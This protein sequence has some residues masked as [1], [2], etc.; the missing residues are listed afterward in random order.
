MFQKDMFIA[1]VGEASGTTYAAGVDNI[2]KLYKVDVDSEYDKDKCKGLDVMLTKMLNE[3]QDS[4]E[5]HK[6]S[7]R[8]TNL[9]R[10]VEC[11]NNNGIPPAKACQVA[12]EKVLAGYKANFDEIWKNERYKW[13]NAKHY[14]T[15]W[16]IDAENF[17]EMLAES[18]QPAATGEG[19]LLSG[20]MY[21]PYRMICAFAQE[22]PDT[23]REM[24]RML[25]DESQPLASRYSKFR[26]SSETCLK[27]Y[28]ASSAEHAKAQNHYQDLRAIM[29]YLSF[30]YPNT[31]FPFKYKMYT[32]FRDLVGF[33]EHKGKSEIW[34][35][36]CYN[37]LCEEVLTRIL[38]DSELLAM[39]KKA[40]EGDDECAPDEKYHL[41]TQTVIYVPTYMDLGLDKS[42]VPETM[43]GEPDDAAM[44][45][46]VKTDI[47]KNTILYGPPGTGKTY[48]TVLY[49]VAIIENKPLKVIQQERYEDVFLRYSDYREMGL[50]EFTTFH[51]SYGYEEF[52]EGIKP[53]MET[54]GDDSKEIEYELSSGLFKSFCEKARQPV[55]AQEQ[56]YGLNANPTVW[57]VSLAG[58]GDNGVRSDCLSKGHIRI[59]WDGYGPDITSE[60]EFTDGG[61]AILNAFMNK[62]RVG[63]IVLSCYSATTVDAIGVVT[64]EYEW[65][66]EYEDYK[67]ARNVSWIVKNIREDI[68][69]L[70]GATMTLSTVYK[71]NLGVADVMG[72][73]AKNLPSAVLPMSRVKNHVFIIDEINRGNISKIFGELITLIEPAKRLGAA[74]ETLAKLPYS[75]KMFGVPDNVYLLGTMNTADRS[76]ATI[77]TALRRRFQFREMQPDPSVLTGVMVEDLSI[78]DMLTR[79]N[80]KISVLYDRDHTIGH[81]YFMPLKASPTIDVLGEIFENSIIPLLQEYFYDDYEKIRLVLGDNNKEA[82]EEQFIIAKG[83]DTA[84]LFGS[85]N[86]GMDDNFHYVINKAAFDN[87]EAYRSI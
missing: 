48:H 81:S 57:K 49:A 29:V 51:Q 41:L 19:A 9:R 24:F 6:I 2:E 20:A 27:K 35:V 15:H 58:T 85:S 70:N 13:V 34:K 86:I 12:I 75:Q 16:N 7:V 43:E 60:T 74:E 78:K 28:R 25:F 18:L 22:D 31:Y 11:R 72:L 67:R 84:E 56:D 64:G 69:D 47:A 14:K 59:G 73:V 26:A 42:Q 37:Q 3:E 52:I 1:Y 80:L 17:A 76:I 10:Y 62:M 68:V 44:D 30:E 53:V 66:P 40:L 82:E 36:E 71:L 23:V 77:D 8:R 21:F 32:S 33:E 83:V 4:R 87:I 79:M 46:S 50:I 38:A 65:H 45:D 5:Q 54:D 63:D 39:Q 61:K 55:L